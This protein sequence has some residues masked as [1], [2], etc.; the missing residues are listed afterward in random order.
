MS[1]HGSPMIPGTQVVTANTFLQPDLNR[2]SILSDRDWTPPKTATSSVR[3]VHD[4]RQDWNGLNE[5][6][7]LTFSDSRL[8]LKVNIMFWQFREPWTT[9]VASSTDMNPRAAP[10]AA[11]DVV[12]LFMIGTRPMAGK[13]FQTESA[14]LNGLSV[15]IVFTSTS[16]SVY[17]S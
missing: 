16:I 17:L 3:S 11:Q 14:T 15:G 10:Y 2:S 8:F 6:E 13:G 5:S 4:M 7:N 9:T 12:L 1:E